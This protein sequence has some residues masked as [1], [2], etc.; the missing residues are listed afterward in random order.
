[1][2]DF[3]LVFRQ[4]L[5]SAQLSVFTHPPH[6][7]PTSSSSPS[8]F[9]NGSHHEC[10]HNFSREPRSGF[11]E[12]LQGIHGGKGNP[13]EG[14]LRSGKG[15]PRTEL[16]S[17]GKGLEDGDEVRGSFPTNCTVAI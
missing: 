10:C 15:P 11:F 4:T 17:A 3:E 13:R 2:R 9:H 6:H 7:F 12:V 16:V 1:M 8:T 5:S 14:V